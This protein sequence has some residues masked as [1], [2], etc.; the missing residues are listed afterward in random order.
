MRKPISTSPL[1]FVLLAGLVFLLGLGLRLFDLGDQSLG[2]YPLRQLQGAV[3]A[4]GI[5]YSILPGADPALVKQAVGFWHAVPTQEPLIQQTVA[6]YAYR[7]LGYE[8]LWVAGVFSTLC[9]MIAGG[10]LFALAYRI[11]A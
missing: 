3:I 8:A 5:Y 9:W 7:L 6:A 11:A 2:F 1:K 4:R 10:A